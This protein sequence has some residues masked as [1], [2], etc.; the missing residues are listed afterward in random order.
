MSSDA[1][2]LP[3]GSV[4]SSPPPVDPGPD[5]TPD[6]PAEPPPPSPPEVDEPD[7]TPVGQIHHYSHPTTPAGAGT[8]TVISNA[9]QVSPRNRFSA[10]AALGDAAIVGITVDDPDAAYDFKGLWR[11][12]VIEDACPVNDHY[13]FNGYIGPQT[14]SRGS[15]SGTLFAIDAGRSWDLELN[16]LSALANFRVVSGDDGDRPA[17]TIAVRLAWLIGTV[18]LPVTD[19][20]LITYDTTALDANDYRGQ[21]AADVL[22]D[23]ANIIG[24]NW[25][26]YYDQSAADGDEV[27]LAFFDPNDT[28]MYPAA[29]SISNDPDDID[30][31]SSGA[32]TVFPPFE[33][34]SV[35]RN[36]DK[37]AAG[38]Y[39]PYTGGAIYEYDNDTS[40]E[41]AFRDQVA[42][43]ASVKT[44]AKAIALADRFL[45]DN[46]EQDERATVT[47]RV[48][49]AQ[50]NDVKHG[51]WMSA[52]L[53]H[54]PGWEAGR[55]CRV[56]RKSFAYPE[57]R[58]QTFY[59]IELE[60]S[61]IKVVST[62]SGAFALQQAGVSYSGQPELPRATTPGRVLLMA[63]VGQGFVTKFP[64]DVRM[65]DNPSV[66]P[67]SAEVP[68]FTD[69]DGWTVLGYERTD[70]S[71]CN[72]GGPCTGF[73]TTP[74]CT[75]GIIAGWAW[76]YVQT[77]EV[78]TV[79]VAV[80]A[81]TADASMAAYVWE[82]PTTTPPTLS[83]SQISTHSS[84]PVDTDLTTDTGN[85]VA[86]NA[87]W[88]AS[89][90]HEQTTLTPHTGVTTIAS[91]AG[92]NDPD[93]EVF[94]GWVQP[95][96]W[97]GQKEAGGVIGCTYS[98]LT[99][100]YT[101]TNWC[102]V[103]I[104]LPDGITLPEITFPGN[105]SA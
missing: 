7:P 82:L 47:I 15:G 83:Q 93:T 25:W 48:L 59:D 3:Y 24:F 26:I 78:T 53:G 62:P 99:P 17:E 18:Y 89:S 44:S 34:G 72:I 13:A 57:N 30:L 55:I 76:R 56:T 31:D 87:F 86:L 35:E 64:T 97:I 95:W 80:S 21:R 69:H 61:P 77:G 105:Q 39:L 66:S 29:I 88:V 37:I 49:A 63:F 71:G 27:S 9:I 94:A 100:T 41:F 74:Y 73:S 19:N 8:D 16:E 12:Y 60:L 68:P 79:P 43:T 28:T 50:L 5:P 32:G 92:D 58:T 40:Y 2:A 84:L 46:D 96:I 22:N 75:S 102:G 10:A 70:A 33:D 38:V 91:T 67:A 52:K 23:M 20:G 65:K 90:G 4:V 101:S 6:P 42:P 1:G 81:E 36:P 11:W 85:L 45:A 104:V 98:P 51:Q 14:V 54:V 103:S